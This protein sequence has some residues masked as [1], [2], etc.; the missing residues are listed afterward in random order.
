MINKNT[1]EPG[2]LFY[3]PFRTKYI[4]DF[5]LLLYENGFIYKPVQAKQFIVKLSKTQKKD[6]VTV[7][8]IIQN[9]LTINYAT[10]LLL[11]QKTY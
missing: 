1:V 3:H 2:K 4:N 6:I 10:Q 7:S 9:K 5:P 8:D 11:N